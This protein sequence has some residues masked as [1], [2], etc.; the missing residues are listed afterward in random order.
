MDVCMIPSRSYLN[1]LIGTCKILEEGEI[2]GF[3]S[4]EAMISKIVF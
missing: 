3:F 2:W 1:Q 4:F